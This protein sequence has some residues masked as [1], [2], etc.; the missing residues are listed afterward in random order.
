MKHVIFWGVISV[1]LLSLGSCKKKPKDEKWTDTITSGIIKVACDE[2]LKNLMDAEVDAFQASTDYQAIINPIYTNE[3]DVIRLL[4]EDSVRL[5][6][7]TRELNAS[8]QKI[9]KDKQMFVRKFLIAFDG[10]ALIA[11]KA[12]PD[13]L[14]G[15]PFIKKIISGEITEWS[16]INPHSNLG[17]IRVI[18]D[19]NKSGILRYVADSLT[20]K[21]KPSSPN[22]YA[23]NNSDEL[24]QKVAELPNAVGIVG[25]NQINDANRWKT[26]GLQ[27]K[28]RLMRI[29]KEEKVTLQNTY[30]PYP[31]DIKNEDYPL[32]RAIY[33]L[34]SDPK[35]G[36][37][38]GFSIFL[39]HDVGQTII[40]KSG[41][42]PA[43][44]DPQNRSVNITGN[45]PE[46]N[47]N[48]NDKQK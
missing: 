23:L 43:V 8:E 34:L 19:G 7:T 12:N 27:D 35:S 31:G 6:L 4:L 30:L 1:L 44:T 22:L 29:G 9:A 21:N 11:N 26:L 37:S 47:N 28:L 33:V 45:Y 2:D 14:I 36:L 39:A 15:L 32:W 13:S 46:E 20:E 42:L 3:N 5:A 17:T 10:I 25:F 48:K 18:F 41:L 40:L 24:M 16:Q 38:S